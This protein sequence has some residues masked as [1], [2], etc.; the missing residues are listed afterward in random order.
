MFL[1]SSYHLYNIMLILTIFYLL[2]R[3][4]SS[5]IIIFVVIPIIIFSFIYKYSKS[6][7]VHVMN[8]NGTVS[9]GEHIQTWSMK[10]F[11][12]LVQE[13]NKINNGRWGI[14]CTV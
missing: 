14:Y 4:L 9:N 6:T 3:L 11:Y 2:R 5:V 1:S 12:I 7:K 10:K 8:S 13:K